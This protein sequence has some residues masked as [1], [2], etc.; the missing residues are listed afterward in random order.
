MRGQ[1]PTRPRPLIL[2]VDDCVEQRDLYELT[3]EPDFEIVTAG[4]GREALALA[5]A[6]IPDA[7]V[8][9]LRMPEMD[10]LEVCRRLKRDPVTAAIPVIILTGA[11]DHGIQTEALI[12]GAAA[13]LTKP[14]APPRLIG[15]L[16]A[17]V[18]RSAA[19]T[20]FK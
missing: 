19:P 13:L 7:I 9:D 5:I 1:D 20:H 17:A 4:R 6:K 15:T 10:G 12:A 11:E 8:L 3:L 16:R 18:A 2:I 14:C